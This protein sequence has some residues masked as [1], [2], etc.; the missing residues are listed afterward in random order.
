VPHTEAV[1]FDVDFT[2]IEPG[3]RFQGT[4]YFASCARHGI[5]VDPG[6]FDMAVAGAAEVLAT[7]S[8][9][10]DPDLFIRYTARIIELMGGS[11]PDVSCVA[12]ELYDAW[13]EHEHFELYEDAR[14]VLVDL[15]SRGIRVGLISNSHRCLESFQRHFALEGLLSAAISSAAFGVMKPDPSIFRAALDRLGV[16]PGRAVMVGDSFTHDI[17]G[18]LAAGMRGVLLARSTP[19]T[20]ARTDIPVIASLRDLPAVLF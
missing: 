12:R 17:E 5:V 9:R 11:S 1:L 6:R 10:Y 7:G 3:P 15:T 19:P 16:Q 20:L 2:L 13:A 14:D 18:A 4:G 8:H